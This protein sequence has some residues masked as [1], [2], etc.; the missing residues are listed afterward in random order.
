MNASHI[1]TYDAMVKRGIIRADD[2][3]IVEFGKLLHEI[4]D[5]CLLTTLHGLI[6][7]GVCK[8]IKR[9]AGRIDACG[10]LCAGFELLGNRGPDGH[11]AR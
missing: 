10:V 9:H 4:G 8:V 3:N 7:N 1:E 2:I 11:L 5:E 6:A